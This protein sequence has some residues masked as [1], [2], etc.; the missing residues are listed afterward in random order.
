MLLVYT[1]DF[2]SRSRRVELN[3]IPT[4]EFT[5]TLKISKVHIRWL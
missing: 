4:R 3:R 2:N 5:K 1:S